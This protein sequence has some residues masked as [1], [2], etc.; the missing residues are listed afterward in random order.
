[1]RVKTGYVR[2][3]AHKKVLK[4]NKGFRG[5]NHRLFKRA[6]EARLHAGQYAFV[7]RKLRKRD[8]RRLWI[9]RINAALTQISSDLNYSRF[10]HALHQHHIE[11]DRKVLADLAVNDMPAFQAVVTAAQA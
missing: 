9:M 3:R 4:A 10:I 7:G 11:L 5:A 8:M 2:H 6:N 1:M